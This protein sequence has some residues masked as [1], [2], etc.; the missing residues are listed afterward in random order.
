MARGKLAILP[1]I[2][3]CVAAMAQAQVVYST[4]NIRQSVIVPWRHFRQTAAAT[5]PDPQARVLTA[6]P[7]MIQAGDPPQTTVDPIPQSSAGSA[8]SVI[9]R[10]STPE[11]YEADISKNHPRPP[12]P[13][14]LPVS[15][16]GTGGTPDSGLTV[17]RVVKAPS[18]QTSSANPTESMASQGAPVTENS[19]EAQIAQLEADFKNRQAER[20]SRRA[21]LAA[22]LATHPAEQRAMQIE[23]TKL[24]IEGQKDRMSTF[25]ELSKAYAT[26]AVNLGASADRMR[27]L[28]DQRKQTASAADAEMSELKPLLPQRQVA[29]ENL[30]K[31]PENSQNAQTVRELTA[32]LN[33][34]QASIQR[35]Q[36][37]TQQAL[38]EAQGLELDAKRLDQVAAEARDHSAALVLAS[39]RAQADQ[40][41]LEDKLEY[42]MAQQK[43]EDLLQSADQ[44]LKVAVPVANAPQPG[45][46]PLTAGQGAEQHQ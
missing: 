14:K 36:Q 44:V 24:Q 30:S 8:P 31:L 4:A 13:V 25:Q 10:D 11:I 19:A 35:D 45:S 20:A 33:Q 3:F 15:D 42:S 9:P 16:Q 40:A 22:A 23:E 32:E 21:E 41:Q 12:E 5:A 38:Q 1:V 43:A 7:G 37:R 27:S 17:Y 29:L 39:Q 46:A 6:G 18:G 26:L 28:A 2:G 34:N